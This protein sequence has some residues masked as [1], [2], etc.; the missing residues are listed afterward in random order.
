MPERSSFVGVCSNS[1]R[2][3]LRD[4]DFV[5]RRGFK[6]LETLRSMRCLAGLRKGGEGD[7]EGPAA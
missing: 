4:Y 2:I 3:R 7:E 6:R 5:S 1:I